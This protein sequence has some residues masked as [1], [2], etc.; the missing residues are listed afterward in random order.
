MFASVSWYNRDMNDQNTDEGRSPWPWVALF[1]ILVVA[2]PFSLGP[3]VW[4]IE[5]FDPNYDS[6]LLPVLNILYIPVTWLYAAADE[7][8]WFD[9]YLDWW[10]P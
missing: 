8:E 1:L 2:Y 4:I 10:Y 3:V 7:P 9:D 6:P 5:T